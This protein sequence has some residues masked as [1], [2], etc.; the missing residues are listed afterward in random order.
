MGRLKIKRKDT[1]IPFR[2]T[3]AFR[4]LLLTVSIVVFLFSFYQTAISLTQNITV[5]FIIFAA[6]SVA[7]AIWAFYNLDH[8]RDAKIPARTLKR[9][10]RR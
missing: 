10:K 8:L 4:L 1:V 3:L 6:L 5:S 7:S 2:Q 9:M